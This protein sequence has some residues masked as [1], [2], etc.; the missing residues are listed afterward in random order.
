MVIIEGLKFVNDHQKLLLLQMIKINTQIKDSRL[1]NMNSRLM[2]TDDVSVF[3][4]MW[5]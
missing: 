3:L 5:P 4:H 2:L 1:S